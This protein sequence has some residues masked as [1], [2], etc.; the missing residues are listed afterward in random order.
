[1]KLTPFT[2]FVPASALE[3]LTFRLRNIR[4][5]DEISG[6]GWTSGTN[7]AYL[8]N[9]C[10]YWAEE[11]DW[12]TTEATINALPN[13]LAEI[14]GYT[15][16]FIHVKAKAQPALPLIITHGWPGSFLEMLKLI[17]L[18]TSDPHRSFDLVIPSVIGFGFSGKPTQAGC[19]SAFIAQL[20]HKLMIGLGYSR[21][22]AQGGDIG[23]GISS[24]L[25]LRHPQNVIGLHLN[26]IPG[27]YQPYLEPGETLVPDVLA[28]QQVARDW[29]E[30]EGAYN[31]I[32]R[33]KPQTLAYALNDSPAGLCAWIVEKFMSWSDHESNL[34]GVISRDE[35]LGNVSL[36]WF[37]Q[38]IASSIRIYRE[39]SQTPLVF[40]KDDFIRQPVAFAK[41]PKEL[42]TP[43]RSYVEKGY[44]IQRWTEMPKG[45]HFAALEQPDLL[46]SDIRQF[47]SQIP[48]TGD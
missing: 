39:N 9:L 18:L 25:S 21:Y 45:G 32:Q 43:P 15:I 24:W 40:G 31:S 38:T 36:Y 27:S 13:F 17:P 19:N 34:E 44:T 2:A 33:S 22:G 23:A 14:D 3:N 1:M 7:L 20:W 12:R 5:P 48:F 10:T 30:R 29:S 11:Y 37:T 41:F 4:W 46:S 8:K 47:F 26:Y 28:Y 6:S 42:P 16:H 35:L